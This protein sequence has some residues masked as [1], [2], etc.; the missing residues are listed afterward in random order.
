MS[1]KITLTFEISNNFDPICEKHGVENIDI[2]K[3]ALWVVN[4]AN[5]AIY[6]SYPEDALRR[7]EMDKLADNL[8]EQ[9]KS[10]ITVEEA[11]EMKLC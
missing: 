7:I 8:R 2:V 4:C 1:R 6:D 3:T 11:E 9:I 10:Q 5:A